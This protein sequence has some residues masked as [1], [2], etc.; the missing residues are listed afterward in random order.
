MTIR[1]LGFPTVRPTLDLNFAS[2]KRLDPRVTFTRASSATYIGSDGLIKT[3]ASNEPRFDHD[4][5]GPCLGLLV[6]EARTNLLTYSEQFNN[7]AWTKTESSVTANAATAPDGTTT[8]N[9][10]VESTATSTHSAGVVPSGSGIVRAFS[11]FAKAAG[12]RYLSLVT[13]YAVHG[14]NSAMFDLQDGVITEQRYAGSPSSLVS[15]AKLPNGWFRICLVHPSY[16]GTCGINFCLSDTP[17]TSDPYGNRVYTGDGTSGVLL[18]GAQL[19]VGSFPTS[20]I[21]TTTA[22][23]TR[24]ADVASITGTNF[25]SWYRQD[26][27]TVYTRGISFTNVYV[28][29]T[30]GPFTFTDSVAS[31]YKNR[32][33]LMLDRGAHN[34]LTLMLWD[35]TGSGAQDLRFYAAVEPSQ[36]QP[37]SIATAI[38]D[39]NS[40]CAVGGTI[41]TNSTSFLSTY[42]PGNIARLGIAESTYSAVGRYSGTI[43]RLTYWPTRLSDAT[44]QAITR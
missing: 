39:A 34:N 22:T 29:D 38:K 32:I 20:Y 37:Y 11:V 2:T 31:E 9:K 30:P 35:P 14:W 18:W 42:V 19:E 4:S 43:S 33:G 7:A 16:A 10:L 26:E 36:F 3:A 24:S 21:P 6:E 27:G 40:A 1:T 17:T 15:I 12:R 13:A 41:R 23:V 44:L 25:S 5:A 28:A 8:A